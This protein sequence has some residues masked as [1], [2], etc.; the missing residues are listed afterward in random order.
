MS[1]YVIAIPITWYF[2]EDWLRDFAYRIEINPFVM[3]G[4]GFFCA[5]IALATIGIKS[6]KTAS[7]NP[8]NSL[9]YE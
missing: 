4:A 3:L 6:V 7:A 9:K 2:A 1:A 5:I 8:V